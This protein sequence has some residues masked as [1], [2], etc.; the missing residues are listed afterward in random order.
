MEK[1]KVNTGLTLG[2]I[3][4]ALGLMSEVFALAVLPLSAVQV[5]IE[6]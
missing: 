6:T 1:E 5:I 3:G 4:T 2:I